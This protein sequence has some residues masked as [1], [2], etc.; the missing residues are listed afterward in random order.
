MTASR[1]LVV[2][3]IS[4]IAV[5]FVYP[6][7][8]IL[9]KS[10][11]GGAVGLGPFEVLLRDSYYLGRIWFTIWQA[12]FST[13]LTLVL[14][15]PVAYLFARHEFPGKSLLKALTTLPFIMPTIV[16]AMGFV[17]LLGSGGLV[18]TGL[19]GV[20]GDNAPQVRIA[21]TLTIIFLAHAF[22]NYS[23]VVRIVSA[24][25]ANLSPQFEESSAMLGA[26]RVQTFL[27]VTLP[28]LLPAVWS[29][30]I[31]V[32]IFSFT[33]FGVVMILGGSQFATMEV[34]IYELTVKLFRLDIAGALA[35]VQIA[36]TYIFMLIY[37]RIQTRSAV[38]VTLVHREAISKRK[39]S[40][41][42]TL[43][44]VGII[45]ILLVVLSPL[46]ALVE[47][48][49][50]TNDGYSL[51]HF[52]ALFS[53]DSG[54]YFYLSPLHVIWNSIRFAFMS[55]V[56]A[57]L[58]GTAAAYVIVRPGKRSSILD[59]LFMLPL[60]VSAVTLGFGFLVAFN[61]PPVDLRGSWLILVIAHSLV[62]YPFVIRTLLP[63]LR[64]M[65]PHLK[66]SAA[67]LGASPF[68]VFIHIEL[69]LIAR[70]LVVGATFAFAVSM[71]EFGA[72]LLLVRSEF[73]TIPVA[74][75]RLLGQ[76]G[77]ANLGQALAMSTLL[78]AV[79]ALG[80]VVIERFRYRD[81]GGF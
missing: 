50:S 31:L 26:G 78:M 49:I 42:D 40:V 21:N 4:F 79:V 6:L 30:A 25:W 1:L 32:Y 69:P 14:G 13:F 76:P 47:R 8:A 7:V 15:L 57:M 34:A 23:I 56:I 22:Y 65:P 67:L 37:T 27:H 66:E 81:I 3:P 77:T 74:I 51:I 48:A 41:R 10:F 53:N 28:L 52:S 80:F 46:L 36:F 75:F 18:N 33:S 17:A 19:S 44:V 11:G 54:S 72:S 71:G 59:S 24:Y 70:A 62:A 61:R 16:V 45:S 60:V 64:G 20:F 9:V 58:V 39:R 55:M 12:A 2:G 43:F 35:I 5:F 38:P 68:R 63:V 73:T 29:S